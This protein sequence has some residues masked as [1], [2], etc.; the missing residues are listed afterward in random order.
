MKGQLKVVSF[1]DTAKAFK[2]KSN[3]QLKASYRLFGLLNK[4]SLVDF[5]NWLTSLKFT[6]DLPLTQRI[7]KSTIFRQFCGGESMEESRQVVEK[8]KSY[9]VDSFMDYGVEAKESEEEYDNT[10]A[11]LKA[12][13]K[14]AE[15][16]SAVPVVTSKVT[17]LIDLEVLEKMTY[18]RAMSAE[19]SEHL[20]R[21]RKRLDDLAAAAAATFSTTKVA[22]YFDAEES[23]LQ[24][25]IDLLVEELMEKF[26]REDAVI[27]NTIQ[28]YRHDRLDYLKQSHEYAK[29]KGF[30][31]GVKLVRG[32]YME[33]ENERA[34]Q[35]GKI[36]P[37][38]TSK[39]ET[40]RDFNLALEYCAKNISEIAFCCA[41]HNEFSNNYLC[42]LIDE[43]GVPRDHHHIYFSQ[44]YGMGDHLSFNLADAGYN[45]AKYIPYGPIREVIPYLSRRAQENSSATGSMSR[46]YRLLRKEM[47]RRSLA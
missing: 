27:F 21:A 45:V 4:R 13:I 35:A 1:E 39:E 28:L 34:Q 11:H 8:L 41:S 9:G 23:W 44:L 7:I 24:G 42:E 6:L 15:A 17:G 43:L 29:A 25:G 26:N 14:Y 46:E 36:S 40:D 3:E 20:E 18:N 30:V 22:I 37:I 32:A 2:H 19:E 33:K 16:E 31:L 47:K 5:G 10:L 38:Q 12:A